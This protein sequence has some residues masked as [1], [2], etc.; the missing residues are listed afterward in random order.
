MK[1]FQPMLFVGLGG[2]GGL[3]GSELE[4]RLR[5]DLCGPDGTALNRLGIQ[6]RYQLPECLQFV[7]ADFSESE[8]ARLPH[9]SADNSLRAAYSRTSRATHDLLPDFDSSPEVTRMLRAVMRSEAAGWLPPRE[10]EPKVT[11][12]RNGAGQL[13]T[14]GR[15]GLFGTL[16]HGLAPVMGPLLQ[17]IDAI[18]RSGE[19]SASSA[20]VPCPAVTCSWPSRW[21]EAPEPGS[22][23]TTCT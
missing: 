7:Y 16:R 4:R 13:P 22:F 10:G 9:L 14:V 15:A 19:N 11:P 8:L 18:S 17:A 23:S 20:A 3:V 12:L 21:Q 1:I 5:A 2:T 6:L